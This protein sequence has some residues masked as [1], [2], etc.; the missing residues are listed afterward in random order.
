MEITRRQLLQAGALLAATAPAARPAPSDRIA[1]G[2][3]GTGSR[4]QELMD[5]LQQD[6]RSEIVAVVDAYKGRLE[7]AVSRTKG[8]AKIY[9]THHEL[10]AEKSIDAVVVAT[11]DHLHKEI[12]IAAMR[13]GKDVYC[14]KPLTYRAADG[15]EIMAAARSSRAHDAGGQPGRQLRHPAQSERYDPRRQAGTHHHDPRGLQSQQRF[16]RLDLSHTAG[17]L[18]RDRQLGHVPGLGHETPLQPGALLPL[19]LLPG[20]LGR[21]RH[22]PVRAPRAPPSIS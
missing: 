21:H 19:A 10:L 13:A 3:I 5:S 9:P 20:I 6:P 12:V 22:R 17:R 4:G 1:V 2:V 14:E 7:R 16:R 15:L 18:A 8:R 11:P